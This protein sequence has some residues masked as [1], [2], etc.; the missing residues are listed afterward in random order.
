MIE[1]HFLHKYVYT[2]HKKEGTYFLINSVSFQGQSSR[3]IEQLSCNDIQYNTCI[4]RYV[5]VFGKTIDQKM[6][7]YP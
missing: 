7:K 5:G 1:I 4:L 6:C 2:N 3:D